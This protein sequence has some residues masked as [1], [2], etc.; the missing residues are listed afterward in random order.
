MSNGK[1]IAGVFFAVRKIAVRRKKTMKR[2]R[3]FRKYFLTGVVILAL[4]LRLFP[5][6]G[7]TPGN[8][9][10][11]KS[12]YLAPRHEASRGAAEGLQS[13]FDVSFYGLDLALFPQTRQ[14]SGAVHIKG[15]SRGDNLPQLVF[16]LFDNMTVDSVAVGAQQALFRHSGGRVEVDL[17]VPLHAGALFSVEIFYHGS[18]E[19]IDFGSFNWSEKDGVP[20]IWTLSEPYGAPAWWPCKDDPADKADSVF[21]HITVPEPLVAASNGILTGVHSVGNSHRTYSWETRYPLSP[22]LVVLAVGDYVRFT[23]WYVTTRGDSMPIEYYVY[24]ELQSAAAIDFAPTPA[25]LHAFAGRFGEYP[26]IREKYG[27]ASVAG[28]ASMEH[29]TLTTLNARHITGQGNSEGVISHELAHHWF[30]DAI[31]VRHW[32]DIWLHEGFASYCEALW[33]EQSRGRAAYREILDQQDMGAFQGTII[34]EDTTD[35]RTLFTP[36][37]YRKGS[38]VLH[39]LRGVLGDETF[40]AALRQFATD[41]RW[42]YGN[43]TTADFIHT[44]ESVSRQELD[45]FFEQW[46]RRA[47]RPVYI[48]Q[49]KTQGIQPPYQTTIEIEQSTSQPF[50]NPIP[51]KM[52]LPVRLAG[53]GSEMTITVW[54]SSSYQQFTVET[55]FRPDTVEI[56]PEDWVLKRVIAT[57]PFATPPLRFELAQNFPN[58]FNGSTFIRFGVPKAAPVKVEIFNTRGQRVYFRQLLRQSPGYHLFEWDGRDNAGRNVASGVY[59]YRFSDGNGLSVKKLLL[60]R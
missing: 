8:L 12:H 34:I 2:S 58:P 11:E 5:Q 14:I 33:A 19:Q 16:D 44:C 20:R 9:H 40:F 42:A 32:R 17:P 41:P 52:V 43:A 30:G 27:M 21:L 15:H 53:G 36:T 25:M 57:G 38:W 22:Y 6:P 37:V 55:D 54:D 48:Y 51:Y 50:E 46:L 56:D 31:T 4:P 1:I 24:P 26:F 60:L 18:P 3:H 28:G 13:G 59:Y 29:Q 39:M 10:L 23:D 47:G 7:V 35:V 49:W 45:W